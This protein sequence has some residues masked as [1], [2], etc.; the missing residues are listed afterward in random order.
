VR[1]Q[2]INFVRPNQNYSE[3]MFSRDESEIAASHCPPRL[4]YTY[5]T[6]IKKKLDV[7]SR[8]EDF[9]QEMLTV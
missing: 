9:K 3:V 1:S 8:R 7:Q 2:A 4:N 6:F 5:T